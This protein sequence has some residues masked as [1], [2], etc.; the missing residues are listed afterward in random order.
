MA[1]RGF[2]ELPEMSHLEA[3]GQLGLLVSWRPSESEPS[4]PVL[5]ASCDLKEM[6]VMARRGFL[7]LPEMSH[8]EACGQL[9]LLVS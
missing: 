4:G 6:S 3:C 1:C 9:G 7:E 8:P 2:L 5:L